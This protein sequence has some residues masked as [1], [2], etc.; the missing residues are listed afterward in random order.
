MARGN[1]NSSSKRGRNQKRGQG[2]TNNDQD[3]MNQL[4]NL[5]N[6]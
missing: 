3:T 1:K 2:S 4:E 5:D 6:Q